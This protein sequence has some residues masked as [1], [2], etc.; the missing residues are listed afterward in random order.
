M[1]VNKIYLKKFLKIL[2]GDNL[3][4]MVDGLVGVVGVW[5][6]STGFSGAGPATSVGTFLRAFA[7]T[8]EFAIALLIVSV[9]ELY[10]LAIKSIKFWFADASAFTADSCLGVGFSGLYI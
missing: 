7:M 10:R 1:K 2:P 3:L 9:G 8:L 6:A 4:S 5:G